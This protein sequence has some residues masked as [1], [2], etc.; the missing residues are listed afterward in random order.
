MKR[1]AFLGR[2][3][4]VALA[5]MLGVRLEW[6]I[7]ESNYEVAVARLAADLAAHYNGPAA[8]VVELLR[9]TLRAEIQLYGVRTL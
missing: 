7:R 3:R 2:M 9:K 5:G 8:E 6:G 4:A 1:R